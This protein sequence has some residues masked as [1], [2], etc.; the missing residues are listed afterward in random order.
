MLIPCQLPVDNRDSGVSRANCRHWLLAFTLIELLVVIAVIGVLAAMLLPALAKSKEAARSTQCR[1]NLRQINLGYTAAVDDDAGQLGWNG[2]PNDPYGYAYQYGNQTSSAGWFA[3]T[4]GLANQGWICP[5]APQEPTNA[6]SQPMPGGF[7]PSFAG[8]VNSA[9]QVDAFYDWWWWG[10]GN[11]EYRYQTNRAGSYVGNSWLAQWGNWWG[12][13]ELGYPNWVWTK[14]S[15]IQHPSKTPIFADGVDFWSCAPRETDFPAVNL[16]TG[17][18]QYG[19]YWWGMNN[20]T[21]PR[22]GSHPSSLTT[23]QPPNKRLPG[24]IDVSFYDGHVEP[25]PL[26]GL[27]QLEWHQG[28]KTPVKRPGL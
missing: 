17:D 7:G 27:W 15:Q 4:W 8:T 13:Y 12:G 16:Q 26:E 14:E 11:G 23:S 6:S 19:E 10:G 1:S 2:N 21:I 9:W 3:K 18:M 20:L 5:D 25:I 22:H 24:S 28:W